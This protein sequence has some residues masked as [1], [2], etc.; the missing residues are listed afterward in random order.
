MTTAHML[1]NRRRRQKTMKFLAKQAKQVKRLGKQ[2][3]AGAK[4]LSA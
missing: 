1:R 4:T 3:Q 2:R